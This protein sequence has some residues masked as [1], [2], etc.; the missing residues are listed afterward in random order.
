ATAVLKPA[1]YG[2]FWTYKV[3]RSAMALQIIPGICY[4]GVLSLT[5]FYWDLKNGGGY[6]QFADPVFKLRYFAAAFVWQAIQM[7]LIICNYVIVLLLLR[8]KYRNVILVET[9]QNQQIL[10]DKQKHE[11][12]LVYISMI[13]CTLEI[14][15]FAFSVYFFVI[16]T[17]VDTRIFYLVY[18]ALNDLYAATPPYLLII[19]ST[20]F[21]LQLTQ[22]LG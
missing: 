14:V 18:N 7:F 12:R 4:G 3:G 6:I 11:R 13:V 17:N 22:F 8:F 2:K 1:S 9:D 20:P 15:C 5:D 10:K 16:N 19:F 21:R